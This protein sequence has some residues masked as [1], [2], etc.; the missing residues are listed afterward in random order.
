MRKKRK[1]YEKKHEHNVEKRKIYEKTQTQCEKNT[2]SMKNT[3]NN[4][5]KRKIGEKTKPT[6]HIPSKP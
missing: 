2:K 6:P 5:K 1:I 3:K 4:V